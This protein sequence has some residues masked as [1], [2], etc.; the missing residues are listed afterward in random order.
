MEKKDT[1][2]KMQTAEVYSSGVTSNLKKA[3][4]TKSKFPQALLTF[5]NYARRVFFC[6]SHADQHSPASDVHGAKRNAKIRFAAK[7]RLAAYALKRKA[8]LTVEAAVAIPVF[9]LTAVSILGIL[10]LYRVQSMIRT[11]IHESAMELGMYACAQEYEQDSPLGAVSSVVCAGY[12]KSRLPDLGDHVKVSL[13]GSSYRGDTINLK[14]QITYRVPVSLIP[15]PPLHLTNSSTVH[16]W[17][18]RGDQ[19]QRILEDSAGKMVYITENESVYHT[20]S[21]CT[22]LELAIHQTE[23]DEISSL[24]NAYGQKYHACEKCGSFGAQ[25]VVYYTEKG[26]RYHNSAS[27]SGLKRSVKMRSEEHTSELQSR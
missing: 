24:R 19:E 8:V 7:N 21:S 4:L 23:A 3:N 20:A 13:L 2:M 16:S 12:A 15:L 17:T 5:F 27:C 25:T 1:G 6:S 14:A 9:L 26:N 18:G 11:S 10:D 22:H